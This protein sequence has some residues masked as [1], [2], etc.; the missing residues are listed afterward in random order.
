[1]IYPKWKTIVTLACA[2]FLGHATPGATRG[3]DDWAQWRGP[4]RDGQLAEARWPERLDE[5]DLQLSWRVELGPGYSG[6][7]V[8]GDRVYV[9]ETRAEKEEVVRALD[10]RTG[11]PI[12]EKY[13]PGAMQVPFFAKRNGDWIRATP[14]LDDGVLYVPG[15]RDVLVALDAQSG[16]EKWRVD[17]VS[18]FGTPLPDFGFASSPLVV[19][20]DLY[21]QAGASLVKLN[22]RTGKVLWRALEDGGGM[23]G[24]A[25]SSPVHVVLGGRATRSADPIAPGWS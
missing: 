5:S 2:F 25:F 1:M 18:Q 24:S 7:I 14:L 11:S 10:R 20:D 19:G 23:L 6:P 3:A 12:W 8:A 16:D 13:W 9:T 17:F 22:K 21:V 4:H 15:M